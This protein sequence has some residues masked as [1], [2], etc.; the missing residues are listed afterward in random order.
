MNTITSTTASAP[1]STAQT[2]KTEKTGSEKQ[3]TPA[4]G[5]PPS[6][7][8]E[9]KLEI[10][11]EGAGEKAEK[12][13]VGNGFEDFDMD[14]FQAEMHAQL[15]DMVKEA[16]KAAGDAGIEFNAIY[17]ADSILYDVSAEE[18]AA[19]VPEYWNA[20]NT[21]QRMVDY[22]MSF[23]SLAPELSDEEYIG[24]MRSAVEDGF[25][26]AKEILGNLPGA[27]GKLFNDTYTSAMQKF[28]DLL[29]KLQDKTDTIPA[30]TA[31]D[32]TGKSS[33][34]SQPM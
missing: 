28:D 24:R 2:T 10:S 18:E 6:P 12:V 19:P 15:L 9:D 23:R 4:T 5:S 32:T 31:E 34:S 7:L 29:S 27:V 14:A 13:S 30:P 17:S 26:Q 21:S 3:T 16:K 20:E 22:A 8:A 33:K 25:K 1:Q 11:E